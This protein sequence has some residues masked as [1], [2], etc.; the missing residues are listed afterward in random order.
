M[1]D[2]EEFAEIV[3]EE[4]PLWQS[5]QL[6][7]ECSADAREQLIARY[8]WLARSIA[9]KA[10]RDR[11]INADLDRG[12]LVQLATV[13]LIEAVDRYDAALGTPFT[14]FARKRIHGAVLD[15][16]DR[17][18]EYRAQMSWT[19]RT[20]KDRTD[21]LVDT[22]AREDRLKRLAE[23]T[24]GLAIGFMLED[25]APVA[26]EQERGG[27]RYD[28]NELMV[29][30]EQLRVI[31]ANLTGAMRKVV[32]M[33]YFQEL[34]FAEISAIL[35]LT[36]GRISQLHGRAILEVRRQLQLI[37]SMDLRT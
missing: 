17:H 23:I 31:V 21:S 27:T 33:H 15:G 19:R 37:G 5:L 25:T 30:Q 29:L 24:V 22:A 18:T 4:I 20:R 16:I 3:P 6:G 14:A 35:G 2:Q 28:V 36:K 10:M 34:S 32:Q 8:L 13:G 11:G 12:D 9:Y 26:E 7:D 1:Q